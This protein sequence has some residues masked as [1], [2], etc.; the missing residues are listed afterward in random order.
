MS[1]VKV[2]AVANLRIIGSLETAS[3]LESSPGLMELPGRF[4][5]CVPFEPS[6]IWVAGA[7]NP[8]RQALLG[9]LACPLKQPSTQAHQWRIHQFGR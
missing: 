9:L 8:S 1:E 2:G 6:W 7:G 3:I 5:S 4:R